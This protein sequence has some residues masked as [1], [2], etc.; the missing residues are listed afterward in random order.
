MLLPGTAV[1][2]ASGPGHTRCPPHCHTQSTSPSKETCPCGAESCSSNETDCTSTG[3]NSSCVSLPQW[4]RKSLSPK[5]FNPNRFQ[6]PSVGNRLTSGTQSNTRTCCRL[7][8][9]LA[10][11][12]SHLPLAAGH[13][14][15]WHRIQYMPLLSLL[16]TSHLSCSK[17]P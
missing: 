10:K 15:N 9:T 12:Q 11:L 3:R 8:F 1:R 14:W 17:H 5:A 6:H 4:Q 7:L 16:L 13:S 2:Q